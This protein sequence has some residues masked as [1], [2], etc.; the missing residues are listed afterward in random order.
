[1]HR[2]SLLGLAWPLVRLLAQLAVLVFIFSTV[3]GLGIEDYPLFVFSGLVAW[4]WF[5]SG[6]SNGTAAIAGQ[7]HLVLQPRFPA[8]VLPAVSVAVSLADV[9]VAFGLLTAVLAVTGDLY[10]TILLLPALVA[11]QFALMCG[12]S[13]ITAA[14]NV[15][16]RDVRSLVTVALTLLFYLTPVF[17]DASRVPADYR[18]VLDLNPLTTLVESYR[19]V[20]IERSLPDP[21]ALALVTAASLV[22]ATLGLVA[23]RRLEGGFADE[24]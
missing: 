21:G 14:A 1:M 15:Y 11:I 12:I 13:W 8:A 23:F 5:S 16:L 17:Y 24:L 3:L 22:L 18:W 7:R 9:L 6:V 2:A 4:V 20:L 19:S 10:W